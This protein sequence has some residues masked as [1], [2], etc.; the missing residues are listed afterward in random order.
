[1]VGN[2]EGSIQHHFLIFSKIA[3]ITEYI[4]AAIK[5]DRES[6]IIIECNNRVRLINILTLIGREIEGKFEGNIPISYDISNWSKEFKKIIS[7][8][9]ETDVKILD[10]LNLKKDQVKGEISYLAKGKIVHKKYTHNLSRR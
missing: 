6:D 7:Y 5:E 3:N 10:Y 4:L 9:E 8:I 2:I 1:M